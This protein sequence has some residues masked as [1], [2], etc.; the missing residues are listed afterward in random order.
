MAED[1]ALM[2]MLTRRICP[3]GELDEMMCEITK[4]DEQKVLRWAI[5]RSMG[6]VR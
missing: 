3:K 6:E 2:L 5:V 4:V 1:K